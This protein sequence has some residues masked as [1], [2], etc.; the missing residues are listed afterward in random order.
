MIESF[1]PF[2]K[3]LA[4]NVCTIKFFSIIIFYYVLIMW[5][6]FLTSYF[7]DILAENSEILLVVKYKKKQKTF[8]QHSFL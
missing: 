7:K 5:Y 1:P 6:R 8:P 3:E 4:S 2:W